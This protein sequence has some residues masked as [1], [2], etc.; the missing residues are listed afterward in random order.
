VRRE[1]TPVDRGAGDVHPCGLSAIA[2]VEVHPRSP[3]RWESHS[4]MAD[5][6]SLRSEAASALGVTVVRPLREGGQKAVLEARLR[7]GRPAALKLV[8][9]DGPH[10]VAARERARREVEV[11][12][13]IDSPFV[14]SVLSP[15]VDVGSSNAAVAWLEELLPGEDLG[16]IIKVRWS[17]S[18]AKAL[19]ESIARG[20]T[21][22]HERGVVHRDLSAG[23]VRRVAPGAYKIID[24]GLARHLEKATMTGTFQ[25][26]T[27][28]YM[29]PEHVTPGARPIPASDIFSVGV[30][31]YRVLVGDV[32]VP[33][34]GDFDE[35][36][37]RLRRSEHVALNVVRNDLPAEA[38]EIVER[39][40]SR[41]SARRFV[42]G[43]ELLSA[44]GAT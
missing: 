6:I 15:L 13:S 36:A 38:Y 4:G 17:W 42:D 31:L 43:K 21:A 11:L 40:L 3:A 1:S 16:D 30:L 41:Q 44:V 24:P 25:P 35:Y 32:P 20:L 29:S 7:D 37:E 14:V 23:N 34:M 5:L 19:A 39:C 33:F 22:F 9:M 12:A 2:S 8:L 10:S 28:G 27:P 18:D 26:G